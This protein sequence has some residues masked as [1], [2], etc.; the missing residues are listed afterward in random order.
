MEEIEKILDWMEKN[1]SGAVNDVRIVHLR[2]TLSDELARTILQALQQSV[3]PTTTTGIVPVPTTTGGPGGGAPFGGGPAGGNP[4]GAPAQI[5]T[6]R[7]PARPRRLR[8][9]RG[10]R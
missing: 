10:R 6:K 1:V 3:V 4:F 7:K 8:A 9:R 5:S 2:S